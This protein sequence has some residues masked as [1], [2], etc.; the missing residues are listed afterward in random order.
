[1]LNHTIENFEM[2]SGVGQ[3]L[4]IRGVI[5]ALDRNDH[6]AE[7]RVLSAYEC[8][9]LFLRPRRSNHKNFPRASEH[10]RDVI[11]KLNIIGC[12]VA[13]VRTFANM[14]MLVLIVC[15]HD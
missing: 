5:R 3:Q 15:F 12:F 4:R 7:L 11:K 9:E 10:F 2:F 6:R 14:G 13:P 8:D 1:M